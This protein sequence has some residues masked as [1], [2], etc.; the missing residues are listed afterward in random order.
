MWEKS[1][2]DLREELMSADSIDSYLHD[3]EGFFSSRT[4]QIPWRS[5]MSAR[6]SPRRRW[7]GSPA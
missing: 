4:L 1:T 5:C 2:D 3:N 6:A 7:P